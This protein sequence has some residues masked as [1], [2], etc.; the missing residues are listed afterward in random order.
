V[1]GV[2]RPRS[3]VVVGALLAGL[4]YWSLYE[5]NDTW[6]SDPQAQILALVMASFSATV[7]GYGAVASAQ[8]Q[9]DPSN[10]IEQTGDSENRAKRS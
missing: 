8:R 4:T 7:V 3:R 2:A 6:G 9:I 10:T 1:E 5:A